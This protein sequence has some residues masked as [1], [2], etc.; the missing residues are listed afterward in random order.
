MR[1]R[2]V[3]AILQWTHGI[4]LRLYPRAFRRDYGD[5]MCDV[6]LD[7]C[8]AH[9]R[10]SSAASLALV[11]TWGLARAAKNGLGAR[12]GDRRH[13]PLNLARDFERSPRLGATLVTGLLQD[14]RF[15]LGSLTHRAGSSML[16]IGMLATGIGA[17]TAIFSL[18][19]SVYLRPLPFKNPH[20]L[21]MLDETAPRW[22]LDLVGISPPDFAAWYE[23]N[24]TFDSMAAFADR[25]MNLVANDRADRVTT[26]I[27]SW[28][29][30][31]VLGVTPILGRD[32]AASDDIED[33]EPVALLTYAAWRDHFGGDP[34]VIGA[35]LQ[36]DDVLR[37]VIGVLPSTATLPYSE[38][39][40]WVPAHTVA[41]CC[42]EP[43]HAGA[44]WLRGIGRLADGASIEQARADLDRAHA[45]LVE[46]LGWSREIATPLVKPYTEHTLGASLPILL[47]LLSAVTILLLIA[48]AN[49][50]GLMLAR[51][52]TRT[53]ELG[54]RAAL[55]ADRYRLVRQLFTESA[56]LAATGGAVGI[57]LGRVAFRGL[58]QLLPARDFAWVPTAVGW[59]FGLFSVAIVGLSALVFG[60][61]PAVSAA[62]IGPRVA[63]RLSGTWASGIGRRRALRA[64][65]VAEITLAVVLLVS[66]GLLVRAFQALQDVD[67]GFRGDALTATI[68]L[69]QVGYDTLDA[70]LAFFESLEARITALPGIDSA[71]LATK[72]PLGGHDG[73]FFAVDNARERSAAEGQPVVLVRFASAAYF[74]AMGIDFIAGRAFGNNDGTPGASQTAVVNEAFARHYW[75]RADVVGKRIRAEGKTS[76]WLTIVGVNR[77]TRHYG[78]E[79]DM[80]PGVFLPYRSSLGGPLGDRYVMSLAVAGGPAPLSFTESIRAAVRA[81]D[82]AVPVYDVGTMDEW[83]TKSTFTRRAYSLLLAALAAAALLLATAGIY[84]TLSYAVGQRQ[85]E[86]S[87]RMALGA[88]RSQVHRQVLAEGARMTAVGLIVGLGL[89][90]FA[91]RA[92]SG[93]LLGIS[94]GDPST[95]LAVTVALVLVALLANW[96]PA[97]R[98]SRANP[99]DSLR[100]D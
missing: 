54:L 21:V 55:G 7:L 23:H 95:Y 8:L 60:L 75:G 46:R 89:S 76:P 12:F 81:A 92:M 30:A 15:G 36:L 5:D 69:P 72:V 13:P 53:R 63:L 33:A 4:V 3:L 83:T 40:F 71:G 62:R 50:S 85:Q 26:R 10:R 45:T 24:S 20:R 6:F 100:S 1:R 94:P 86:I 96:L 14:M 29:L 48:C 51:A 77:D 79:Q 73:S 99:A 70:R 64:L 19:E 87:I 98:A 38:V 58:L 42:N 41:F 44:Y 43:E 66:A 93:V 91:A 65:V 31:T 18:F 80:R 28:E 90:V 88:G 22:D 16:I 39:D 25:P 57:V 56:V 37:S 59:R 9:S 11:G 17:S 84:T 82:P 67:K 61:A 35:K 74:N 78:L 2:Q 27:A 49:I 34:D 68:A 32:F 97:L 52:V 47:L